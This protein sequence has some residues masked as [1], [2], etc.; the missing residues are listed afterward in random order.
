M[1]WHSTEQSK[2]RKRKRREGK[3]REKI[4]QSRKGIGK[5]KGGGW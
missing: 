4:E 1:A 2:R 3:R 5:D